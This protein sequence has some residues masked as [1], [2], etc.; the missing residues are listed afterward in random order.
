ME[1]SGLHIL[2]T[3]DALGP[4]Q[5]G[6]MLTAQ[7][8]RVTSIPTIELLDPEDWGPFD[9]GATRLGEFGWMVFTSINA[10]HQAKKRFDHLG[11]ASLPEGLKLAAVGQKTGAA[12]EANGWPLHLI[13]EDFQAEGLIKAFEKQPLEGVPIF[14]PRAQEARETLVS[15][16]GFLGAKV[17]LAPVYRNEPAWGNQQALEDC[18]F[19]DPPHWITFTSASTVRNLFLI[20]E[21]VPAQLPRLASIGKVTTSELKKHG[22][23][24]AVTAHP[25]TLDGLVKAIIHKENYD[26]IL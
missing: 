12:I 18:L 13:P 23:E 19:E 22:L 8:A 21:K 20:V 17:H 2:T 26:P 1:L 11:Q 7:G 15:A 3:R 5:L 24:P 14:F 4:D 16:L 10:V 6:Q 9:E 25:Q